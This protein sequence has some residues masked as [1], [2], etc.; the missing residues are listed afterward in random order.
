ML[1]LTERLKLSGGALALCLA[2]CAAVPASLL[3][4]AVVHPLRPEASERVNEALHRLSR[5]PESLPS[6]V[7]AG[8]ASLELGDIE[9]AQGFFLR[10]QGVAPGDGGVLAGHAIVALR[11]QDPVTALAL[12][13]RAAAAGEDL[14]AYAS[15]HGLAHDLVGDNARAQQLYCV[16][17][18]RSENDE[19]V[20]RLALSYAIAGDREASEAILLPLLQR[21]D[22]AAY[23]VRA[24]ALSIL[25]REDEAVSIAETMLPARLAQR[26]SPYLRYMPRLT[27]AQQAAAANLGA[28]PRAAEIGRDDPQLA[29]RATRS[30][31]AA[32]STGAD[33][34]LIPG[35]RPLGSAAAELPAVEEVEE[36]VVEETL[37]EA[38][39]VEE[40]VAANVTQED[41]PPQEPIVVA[42]LPQERESE[43]QQIEEPAVSPRPAFSISEPASS[44]AELEISLTEAFSD[45]SLDADSQ[46][47]RAAPGAV[48][49]TTIE[50]V[51]EE[52]A[53]PP[54][55]AHPSRHWVQVA[56]G[57][58]TNA[59][60]FDW[61]RIVR[62]A[63]GLLDAKQAYRVRWN[64]TNR[65]VTGPF[66]SAS[67]AQDFVT[68]LGREGV[69]S[70]R[71]T[72]SVGEQ[73]IG[74]D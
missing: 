33:A 30:S 35:G 22:L 29:R 69:D 74:L 26:L 61:R 2:A 9:A 56:T 3:A 34:R 67:E 57:Q 21:R 51:R 32:R 8:R 1:G 60:R 18:S 27:P 25:G 6:L 47:S 41:V 44:Q 54:P 19:T 38:V 40:A 52:P 68:A 7:E 58:D 5:N 13:A 10:A 45:F 55:P 14:D 53:P 39:V 59:F 42:S 24:F 49:I 65:L 11:R 16:A 64:Q 4:Q 73:V 28:F 72:S 71:F 62:S 31:G 46:P 66:D 17:L 63:G 48:D 15:D 37:V 70:F 50:P 23:R 12:F 20:R 36:A 43:P